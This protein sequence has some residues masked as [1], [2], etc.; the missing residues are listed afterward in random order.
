MSINQQPYKNSDGL[1]VFVVTSCKGGIGKSTVCANLAVALANA[2]RRV[3]CVDCDYSNRSLDLIFGVD[4]KLAP[5]IDRYIYEKLEPAAVLMKIREDRLW[6]IPGPEKGRILFTR[7]EFM[8]RV[9]DAALFNKCDT[10]LIDTPGASDGILPVVA[11]L[12]D[13]GIVVASHMPT[14]IRGAEKTGKMLAE[15]GVEERF[16]IV[17]RFDA[18]AV[19]AGIR[20]GV[21]DLIDQTYIRLIGVVPDSKTLELA[22]EDGILADE[23][24]KDRDRTADAFAEIADR[25]LGGRKPLMSYLP[26]GMRKRLTKPKK[27]Q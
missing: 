8:A 18:H 3:L 6:F 4:C 7:D 22:Q 14:S 2:G 23:I 11:P 24:A 9:R 17:N 15:L 21:N 27:Q 1:Y 20:P 12:A 13:T 5:G 10:V 19:L 16:L 25:L 26:A